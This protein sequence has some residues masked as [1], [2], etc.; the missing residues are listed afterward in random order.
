MKKIMI[1][2]LLLLISSFATAERI[3]STNAIELFVTYNA[4]SANVPLSAEVN[5]AII[6]A[7]KNVIAVND[8]NKLPFSQRAA[9][10]RS[11]YWQSDLVSEDVITE[12]IDKFGNQ[13]AAMSM[14]AKSRFLKSDI[15]GLFETLYEPLG[16]KRND[17]AD[18]TAAYWITMWMIVNKANYPPV[19]QVSIIRN[20]VSSELAKNGA[21]K[22]PDA[23]KQHVAQT[24]QWKAVLGLLA[25]QDSTVDRRILSQVTAQQTRASGFDFARTVLTKD[26]L[27]APQDKK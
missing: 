6:A 21:L 16:L 26:G 3:A 8:V 13:S 19:A 11:N 20:K 1:A 18:A 4:L 17:L 9:L 10:P 2:M 24:Y 12:N 14:T 27:I 7:G 23:Q 25:L 15:E 22:K 5:A